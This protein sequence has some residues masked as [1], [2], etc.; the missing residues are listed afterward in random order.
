MTQRIFIDRVLESEK[1]GY[2]LPPVP[3]PPAVPPGGSPTMRLPAY[4]CA[5]ARSPPARNR[6]Q[7]RRPRPDPES[8]RGHGEHG[9]CRYQK[10]TFLSGCHRTL[11][12]SA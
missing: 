12:L 5:Q 11:R 10:R 7:W 8:L 4:V 9:A 3:N 2:P 6:P 1:G